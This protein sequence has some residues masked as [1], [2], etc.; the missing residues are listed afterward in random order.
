VPRTLRNYH[1]NF[2]TSTNSSGYYS[3]GPA[4]V[5]QNIH[6]NPFL[7]EE[8]HMDSPLLLPLVLLLSATT[9]GDQIRAGFLYQVAQFAAWPSDRM[10]AGAPI[11]FCVIGD[12]GVAAQLESLA[13]GRTIDGRDL[14]VVRATAPLTAGSCELAYIGSTKDL[15][16][17]LAAWAGEPVLLVGSAPDFAQAGGM[18]NLT[19]SDSRLLI[20]VNLEAVRGA[21]LHIRSQLLKLAK[22]LGRPELSR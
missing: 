3:S 8:T 13:K 6:T 2:D 10:S 20:E 19:I 5:R 11:R 9:N 1:P 7:T 16:E 22:V 15:R 17:Q 4:A 14:A 21:R 12:P 18:V